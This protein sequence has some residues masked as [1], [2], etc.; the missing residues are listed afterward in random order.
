MYPAQQVK[1]VDQKVRTPTSSC[2][3]GCGFGIW[4]ARLSGVGWP[5]KAQYCMTS[6]AEVVRAMSEI[7]SHRSRHKPLYWHGCK[8]SRLSEEKTVC[9]PL[10]PV[11]AD[12]H[13]E[14]VRYSMRCRFLEPN[15]SHSEE[16]M[17]SLSR[18]RHLVHQAFEVPAANCSQRE[19]IA[20]AANVVP[21]P[22]PEHVHGLCSSNA[23]NKHVKCSMQS[24]PKPNADVGTPPRCRA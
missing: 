11:I 8:L 4:M 21:A 18:L 24:E 23:C 15:S 6:S 1:F 3:T 13:N 16:F 20:A 22:K 17:Q 2:N 12:A 14:H 10:D 19:P 7:F 9:V 5:M